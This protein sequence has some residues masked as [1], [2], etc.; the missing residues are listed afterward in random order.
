MKTVYCI[1]L[2]FI[3]YAYFGYPLAL[4][5]IGLVRPKRVRKS[6]IMPKVSFIV[7]VHNEERRIREKIDNTLAQTYPPNSIEV[8]VASDCSTDRTDE[9]VKAFESRGV[10]LVRAAERKGK[11]NAQREAIRNWPT[12][13][14]T[15][16][17]PPAMTRSIGNSGRRLGISG[18]CSR[19]RASCC[20]SI[21][22]E[23]RVG[24]SRRRWRSS[25]KN[26]I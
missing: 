22:A 12:T 14:C 9:I 19:T 6:P 24:P 10:R 20:S 2:A 5:I 21:A 15:T 13:P 7:T 25:S 16:M 11:E 1:S 8:I 3:L 18:A 4:A 17:A 23:A 26:T